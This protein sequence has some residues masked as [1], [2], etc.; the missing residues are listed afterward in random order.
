MT[1]HPAVFTSNAFL[2]HPEN[3][4]YV[5]GEQ[6]RIT[7]TSSTG[8]LSLFVIG[9]W[10]LGLIF[11]LLAVQ[12]VHQWWLIETKGMVTS[13]EFVNRWVAVADSHTHHYVSFRFTHDE[14][15]YRADQRIDKS[16][17]DRAE[18]GVPVDVHYV[19]EDPRVSSVAGT[20]HFPL[21]ISLMA[22]G[23]TAAVVGFT[24]RMWRQYRQQRQ[25]ERDGI[26]LE[27]ILIHCRVDK[28]ADGDYLLDIEYCFTPPDTNTSI[29]GRERVVRNDLVHHYPPKMGSAVQIL[30]VHP[31]NYILL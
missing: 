13:G 8:C 9:F 26:L 11:A 7:K 22:L 28:N 10:V 17:Y 31:Q 19:P 24:R 16:V 25:L 6:R 4:A 3:Q 30:Y 5:K 2:L 21:G 29:S 23:W 20:N 1:S 27:G 15:E 14:I 18:A 12:D